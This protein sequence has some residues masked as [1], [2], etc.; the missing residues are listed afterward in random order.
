MAN[1]D[2]L[3]GRRQ[4]ILTGFGALAALLAACSSTSKPS[5]TAVDLTFTSKGRLT[6][7]CLGRSV[8]LSTVLP[9]SSGTT[10]GSAV[11]EQ[12]SGSWKIAHNGSSDQT[13]VPVTLDGSLGSQSISLNGTFRLMPNF[14]FDSG[15]VIGSAGGRA[16]H[17][18]A[19]SASGEST[20]SVNVDGT[21]AGTPFSL[22]ATIAGDLQS[23]LIRGTVGGKPTQLTAKVRSGAIHITGDYSGPP[24]LFVIATG[25]LLY[26]L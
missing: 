14:L 23:G 13:V 26:F 7:S 6:D 19:S 2:H 5:P 25:S 21:F 4:A 9:A 12:V 22:Y 17:T 3:V 1:Q 8:D 15:T 16:V 24:A 10:S 11:G 18:Q 20:S